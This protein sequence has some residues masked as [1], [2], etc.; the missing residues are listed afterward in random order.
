V[1]HRRYSPDTARLALSALRPAA[2][3]LCRL[4]REMERARPARIVADQP[5]DPR[6]FELLTRVHAALGEIR[7]AT[8]GFWHEPRAAPSRRRPPGGAGYP[9][10][11]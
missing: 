7:E 9:G 8:R 6:Y 1:A 5:V 3:T 2:E 11:G 4:I 10:E